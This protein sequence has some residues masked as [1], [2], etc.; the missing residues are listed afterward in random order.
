MKIDKTKFTLALNA[1]LISNDNIEVKP[2]YKF[3]RNGNGFNYEVFFADNNTDSF[4]IDY[5]ASKD[6]I[7]ISG[8]WFNLKTFFIHG[9]SKMSHNS[10]IVYLNA[11]IDRMFVHAVENS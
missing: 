3:S 5:I 2:N 6:T 8:N 10:L 7:V 9:V 4:D 11:K 1:A